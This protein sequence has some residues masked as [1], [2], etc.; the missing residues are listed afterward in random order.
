MHAHYQESVWNQAHLPCPELQPLT[1][2]GWMHS[3]GRP[4]YQNWEMRKRDLMRGILRAKSE[5]IDL[6]RSELLK[7]QNKTLTHILQYTKDRFW[8][9]NYT[10]STGNVIKGEDAFAKLLTQLRETLLKETRQP[11]LTVAP[12]AVPTLSTSILSNNRFRTLSTEDT[13]EEEVPEDTDTLQ[14]P[15]A[16]RTHTQKKSGKI[17]G[18]QLHTYDAGQKSTWT[19]PAG[20]SKVIVLGDSNLSRITKVN[21]PSNSVE[22][23]SYSGAKP[24]HFE[25]LLSTHDTIENPSAVIINIGINSRDNKIQTTKTQ[26]KKVTQSASK[27]FPNAQNLYPP[28]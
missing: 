22:I 14:P 20:Q 1:E 26:M 2:M 23:H 18:L 6:F 28:N 19:L 16:N 3:D 12:Q 11:R 15:R 4:I 17:S 25:R 10:S 21:T 7:S 13:T 27:V 5:Q 24:C 9:T 8:A